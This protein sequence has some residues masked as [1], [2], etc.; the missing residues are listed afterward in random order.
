VVR[1][2]TDVLAAVAEGLSP[3]YRDMSI[4]I[5]TNAL[6]PNTRQP[7]APDHDWQ[8]EE[9]RREVLEELLGRHGLLLNLTEADAQHGRSLVLQFA[10]GSRVAVIF[11]QGFGPWRAPRFAR[12]DFG[13]NAMNQAEQLAKMQGWVEARGHTYLVVTR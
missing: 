13:E 5:V 6:K 1:L 7:F 8:Y 12:F 10:D 3:S 4:T 9:D 2:L 11:D